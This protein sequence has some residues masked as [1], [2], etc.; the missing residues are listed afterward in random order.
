MG[1]FCGLFL[2]FV[3]KKTNNKNKK[4]EARAK[5]EKQRQ[6]FVRI[7]SDIATI[8]SKILKV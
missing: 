8:F 1:D 2:V 6:E 7:S 5:V 4:T 3:L